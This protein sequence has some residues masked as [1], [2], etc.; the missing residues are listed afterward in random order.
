MSAI[1]VSTMQVRLRQV[2]AGADTTGT[3]CPEILVTLAMQLTFCAIQTHRAVGSTIASQSIQ[4]CRAVPERM[5]GT[6]TP[7]PF[8][9][10]AALGTT[11]TL[12]CYE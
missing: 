6:P 1:D 7:V 9:C 4:S 10:T 12:G 8:S 2:R 11:L 3:L 5:S